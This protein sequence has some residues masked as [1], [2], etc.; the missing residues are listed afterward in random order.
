MP[1]SGPYQLCLPARVFAERVLGIGGRIVR[2][3]GDVD[4]DLVG[5]GAKNGADLRLEGQPAALV[6]GHGRAVHEHLRVV[7]DGAEAEE[8]G[9]A[10]PLGG[11]LERAPVPGPAVSLA[12]L[13][14]HRLPGRRHGARPPAIEILQRDLGIAAEVEVPGAIER[15]GR[16]LHGASPLFVDRRG[17]LRAADS[18]R[19]DSVRKNRNCQSAS[20]SPISLARRWPATGQHRTSAGPERMLSHARAQVRAT[21]RVRP[22]PIAAGTPSTGDVRVLKLMEAEILQLG[23]CPLSRPGRRPRCRAAEAGRSSWRRPTRRRVLLGPARHH[24]AQ[25]APMRRQAYCCGPTAG[26]PPNQPV[27]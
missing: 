14:E 11:Q 25:R 10:Q 27:A 24:A 6:L 18:T 16:S 13:G 8:D 9:A 3:R 15:Q 19:C 26:S 2:R 22:I 1:P 20:C 12:Q 21:P 17:G 7:V 5:A 4:R 23:V